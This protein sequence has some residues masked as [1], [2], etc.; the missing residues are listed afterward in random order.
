MQIRFQHLSVFV[1]CVLFL[2]C[3]QKKEISYDLVIKNARV[4]DPE[5]ETD[6]VLFVGILG[7][8]IAYVGEEEIHGKR[9]VD[10]T[11]K[12]L[13]PGFVDLHAHGQTNVENEYQAFDGVTTAL[14]LEVGVDTLKEWLHARKGRA[15]LNYGASACQLTFRNQIIGSSKAQ[16]GHIHNELSGEE[17]QKTLPGSG[18]TLLRSKLET[19]LKDG[20][21][22]IG[23][24]V[25]YVPEAS[26]AEI[27]FVYSLAGEW[28]VPIFSHVREGGGVAFQQAIADAILQKTPLHI[29]HLP[30]M[31]R[32]DVD[33]CLDLVRNAQSLGHPITTEMYPYTAG[34]T[35]ISSAIFDAGWE[36]RL[37]CGYAD[38]Q[39]VETGERLNA[40]SFARYRKQGGSVI[41]HMLK[42]EWVD[43]ALVEP[44]MMIASDGG[45][46]SPL[47]H[48]RG[49]GTFTKILREMVREKKRIDLPTA[50]KKMTLMPVQVIEKVA[51]EMKLRG[52]IQVGCY[53][54]LILFDPHKV[55][56]L[57][58]YKRG[59]VRAEG[60]DYVWVNGTSL[61]EKGKFNK[62]SFPG[63][64]IKGQNGTKKS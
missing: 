28:Q 16:S 59:F 32:K 34:N 10:G 20:A 57:S 3:S 38:L 22:G 42:E 63:K 7:D 62:N 47:G 17:V 31:A 46:F 40:E 23:V 5:T 24:P 44:F 36:E 33:F 45:E 19:A 13:S 56:D 61:I 64:A 26:L 48:P 58:T 50:I 12:V 9:E 8:K 14:E 41:V 37:G 18:F 53:A 27:S 11:G 1:L 51:P 39:W 4:I 52:R 25:G 49:S 21:I 54:D 30:S 35:E 55:R 60:M 2:S 43:R 29:C 15:Y 6:Q